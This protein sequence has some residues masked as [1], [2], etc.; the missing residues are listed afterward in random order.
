MY[1]DENGRLWVAVWVPDAQWEDAY[2]VTIDPNGR[3]RETVHDYGRLWDTIVEVIDPFRGQVLAS[4][5]TDPAIM[6][7]TREGLAFSFT[8]GPASNPYVEVW[9]LSLIPPTGGKE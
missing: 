1:E 2:E 7:F 4:E 3:R 8:F 6:G 5:R 9:E